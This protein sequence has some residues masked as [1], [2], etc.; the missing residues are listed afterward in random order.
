MCLVPDGDLFASIKAGKASVV[1]DRIDRFTERGVLLESGSELEADI[2]VTATGLNMQMIGG[3]GVTVDGEPVVVNER[4][5]Y[6]AMMLEG[7]PNGMAD[8]VTLE[9]RQQHADDHDHADGVAR[10]HVTAAGRWW[11]GHS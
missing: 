6:K 4:M 10:R 9:D 2:V 1:T 7:V 11:R 3:V 8:R 5:T